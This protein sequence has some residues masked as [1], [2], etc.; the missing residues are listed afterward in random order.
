[1]IEN[2]ISAIEKEVSSGLNEILRLR[3]E[4]FQKQDNS[5]VTSGDLLVNEI[6]RKLA[7]SHLDDF[8]IVSEENVNTH[9]H[10][11]SGYVIVV[12]PI[13]G[14]E[15]FTSG[16]PQWGVS[17]SCFLDG[18]HC[19]SLIG[20]PELKIWIRSGQVFSRHFSRIAALSSSLSMADLIKAT[21]GYEYRVTGCCVYNMINVIKGSFK[22]FE[23]PKGANSWDIL[24][25]LNLA[26]ENNL[27]VIVNDE[28]YQ[29]QYLESDRKYKFRINNR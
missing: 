7:A 20:C 11:A 15:N 4:R 24:A 23:N 9:V 13:D 21:E 8:V 18:S 10:G 14:T 5:F 12:D 2:F 26:L 29:G 6:I 22:S 17:V 19:I 25:G 16:L 1:M 28:P 27:E 3:D